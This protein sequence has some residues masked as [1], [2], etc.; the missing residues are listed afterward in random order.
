VRPELV[1]SAVTTALLSVPRMPPCVVLLCRLSL[2][3]LLLA[4]LLLPPEAASSFGHPPC[5]AVA[6]FCSQAHLTARFPT[7]V[8]PA[9]I[10]SR[11]HHHA[12]S[13]LRSVQCHV[14]TD[15]RCSAGRAASTLELHRHRVVCA[16]A[17]LRSD[18]AG[19]SGELQSPP[20]RRHSE[21]PVT[22]RAAGL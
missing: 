12:T 10:R 15:E 7:G 5:Q 2:L 22:S 6:P 13:F 21:P 4:W 19:F 17:E 14:S 1:L 16:P 8:A 9:A 20:S 11:E 18:A 3:A